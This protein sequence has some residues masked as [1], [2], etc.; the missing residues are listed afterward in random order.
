VGAKRRVFFV[1]LLKQN[2]AGSFQTHRV[3]VEQNTP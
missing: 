2:I 1:K 3:R